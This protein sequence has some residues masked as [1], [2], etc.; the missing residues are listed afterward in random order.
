MSRIKSKNTGPELKLRKLLYASCLRYRTNYP[1]LGKPDIVFPIKRLAVFVNGCF[2]HGHGCKLDHIPKSNNLFWNTKIQNN[3]KRD[4]KI[5]KYLKKENWRLFI[6]WECEIEKNPEV[7]TK[8]IK[9][10]ISS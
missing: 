4:K 8:N 6:A 9:R 3:R 7:I 2:W 1:L 10:I 5:Q